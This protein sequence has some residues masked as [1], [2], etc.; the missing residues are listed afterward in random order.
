MSDQKLHDVI[1]PHGWPR[2]RGY[3]NGISAR[4]RL[5]FVGGQIGWT[6][7][8]RFESDDFVQQ[9]RQALDNVIA[10]LHAAGAGPE[11][12]TQLTWYFTDREEYVARLAEIGA[13]WRERCGRHYPAMAAVEV[14]RLV[15]PRARI[16]LQAIAV[17]PD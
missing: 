9:F 12:M 7:D 17:V 4:G 13:V 8:E 16:E 5:V 14:T 2:P 15:E 10:V 3:A 1:L 6:P 11:H